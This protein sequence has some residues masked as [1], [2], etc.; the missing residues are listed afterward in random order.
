MTQ[1][2]I[3]LI[4]G[5]TFPVSVYIADV[6]GNNQS[7]LGVIGS[8]PVPPVVKYNSTIPAIFNTAPQIM[9]KL[10]DSNNCE[11]F[12]ILDCTFGCAFEITVQVS[13][14]T[15]DITITPI[16]TLTP[17]PTNTT[18]PVN[19][20]P[21]PTPTNTVTP[22]NTPTSETPTPTPT[23]TITPSN[24]A[25][26]TTTNTQTP[27]TTPTN[28]GTLGTSPTPTPTNTQTPT[29]TPTATQT[30]TTTPILSP[31]VTPTNTETPTNTPTNTITPTNTATPTTTNTQTPSETPTNTPTPTNTTTNTGTPT[32]TPT[33]T[34]TP[35][36]TPS[37]TPTNTPTPTITQ[38]PTNTIT[39]TL[40]Q[41][42]T[43]TTAGFM[44]YIFAEPQNS[45]AD[46]T[47]LAYATASNAQEWY[48]YFSVGG[49]P[50]NGA[51]NYSGDLNIYAHQPSF[52]NGGSDFVT[53]VTL[54]GP[55]SQSTYL[56]TNIQV[57]S[58][59]VNPT[60]QYFYSIWL[61]LNGI[62]NSLNNYVM[63]VGT[64]P[65]GNDVQSA[66]PSLA[67]STNAFNV[68]VTSG[69]AIPSGT[70]RV[71]WVTP[72]FLLTVAT[73]SNYYNATSKT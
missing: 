17:T 1:V 64:S 28:T 54:S 51:G 45:G 38:T 63:D 35:T 32:N 43:S 10:I 8:G 11:I 46:S 24:T 37:E 22:T 41:T 58:S 47:L 16:T 48:S 34:E 9:L 26:P 15:V 67:P 53:P 42:P 65:S 21:T 70:Y 59:V 62:G 60:L 12:K 18:T 4:S 33:N 66:V 5:G 23:N 6:Y 57:S 25:T 68:T 44:A 72:N 71:V 7:L 14:C 27:T 20:T 73:G 56:F 40:T 31:S 49:P 36:Q 30:P 13:S 39:P 29:T 3:D 52:V 2:R 69:A 19:E 61:P 50:N 55:I